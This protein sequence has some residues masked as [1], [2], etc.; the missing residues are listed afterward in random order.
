[1]HAHPVSRAQVAMQLPAQVHRAASW[2]RQQ[3]RRRGWIAKKA[4]RR[5]GE[6][7]QAGRLEWRERPH[8]LETDGQRIDYRALQLQCEVAPAV[9]HAVAVVLVGQIQSAD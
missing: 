3:Q 9:G 8:A 1:M 4:R 5:T 2:S 6:L 7:A